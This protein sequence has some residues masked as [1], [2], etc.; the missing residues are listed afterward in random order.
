MAEKKIWKFTLPMADYPVVSMPK[1][2]RVLSVGVQRGDVQV[3]ALVDP[4]APMEDRRFKVAG[5]GHYLVGGVENMRFIGTVHMA[6]GQL[7]WH[8]FEEAPS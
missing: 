2:A 1:G 3:W 4:E 5:T 7:V 6:S 8:I